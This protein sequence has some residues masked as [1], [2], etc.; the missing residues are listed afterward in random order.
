MEN[1]VFETKS[2]IFFDGVKYIALYQVAKS[3]GRKNVK[4]FFSREKESRPASDN[5]SI[6][7]RHTFLCPRLLATWYIHYELRTLN[8]ELRTF[9]CINEHI[10]KL[11][12][13]F[14]LWQ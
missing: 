12:L 13:Y 7:S 4:R 8:N 9:L 2:K 10:I 11:F 6:R 14:R 3:R 5:W 1:K